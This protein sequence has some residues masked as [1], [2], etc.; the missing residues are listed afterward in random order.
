MLVE[1]FLPCFFGNEIM[2]ASNSLSYCLFSSDWTEQNITYKKKMIIF[3]ERLRRP[4]VITAGKI[5]NLSL[6]TFTSVCI[7]I[8]VFFL[9]KI[10]FY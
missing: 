9:N 7:R 8:I 10:L 6:I 5:V 2:L 4:I 3:I 1:I